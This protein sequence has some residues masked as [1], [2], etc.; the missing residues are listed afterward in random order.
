MLIDNLQILSLTIHQQCVL[1]FFTQGAHDGYTHLTCP[2]GSLHGLC[3]GTVQE[4]STANDG[5]TDFSLHDC[6][7]DGGKNV[8]S[9]GDCYAAGD[10]KECIKLMMQS[11]GHD[12]ELEQPGKGM[13]VE[14]SS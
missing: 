7:G 3:K 13:Q 8:D 14:P 1:A 2:E 12:T 5:V 10:Q 6:C 4:V 9:A 11:G